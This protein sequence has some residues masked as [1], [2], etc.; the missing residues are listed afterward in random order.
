MLGE[1]FKLSMFHENEFVI[2]SNVWA[3]GYNQYV[4]RTVDAMRN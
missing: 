3:V 2:Y 1:T 4:R